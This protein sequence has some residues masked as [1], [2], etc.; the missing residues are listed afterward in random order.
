M[1]KIRK[2]KTRFSI[3]GTCPLEELKEDDSVRISEIKRVTA[4]MH[5]FFGSAF[6]RR[7]LS[8]MN[9]WFWAHEHGLN[10]T[11]SI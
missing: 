7:F 9:L 5:V 6:C 11:L 1:F 4:S 2:K 10:C 3:S 8:R